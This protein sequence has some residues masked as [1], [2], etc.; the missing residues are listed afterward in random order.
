MRQRFNRCYDLLTD[1]ERQRFVEIL[2]RVT[3]GR[4]FKHKSN[5]GL[6]LVIGGV[7]RAP[8]TSIKNVSGGVQHER[9]GVGVSLYVAANDI[10]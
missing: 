3:A 5:R 2:E 4:K 6:A 9:P 8:S 1:S 10:G 7:F